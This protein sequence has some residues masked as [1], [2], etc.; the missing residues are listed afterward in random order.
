ML[1]KDSV[2]L[3]SPSWSFRCK[4]SDNYSDDREDKLVTL[5]G[6]EIFLIEKHPELTFVPFIFNI[7]YIIPKDIVRM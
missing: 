1:L 7:I 6:T 5:K 2:E 4:Q 3:A